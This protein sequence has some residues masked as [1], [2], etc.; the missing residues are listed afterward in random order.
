MTTKSNVEPVTIV[1]F[2][3][4]FL[5]P[6]VGFILGIISLVRIKNNPAKQ[7]KS[8]AIAAIIIGL[9]LTLVVFFSLSSFVL[10]DPGNMLLY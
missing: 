3:L 1:A 7:G 4:S 5:L 9:I 2:I 6:L 8:L 10:M